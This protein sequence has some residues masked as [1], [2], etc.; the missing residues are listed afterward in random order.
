ML[1]VDGVVG[2]EK[3]GKN[4][5]TGVVENMGMPLGGKKGGYYKNNRKWWL[6]KEP[7]IKEVV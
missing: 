2:K 6:K 1:D 5:W 3:M 4:G 7:N